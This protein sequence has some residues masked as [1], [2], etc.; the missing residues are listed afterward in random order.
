M[1]E[2]FLEGMRSILVGAVA[3]G[4][5]R[6]L[7]LVLEEGQIIDTIIH[8]VVEPLQGLPETVTAVLMMFVQS[9]LNFLMPSS[10]GQAAATLPLFL[11]IGD[12]VGLGRR[13]TIL[14]FQFGDS[15]TNLIYPTYGGL[16]AF[17]MFAK[18]PYNKW[19]RFMLPFV[20]VITIVAAV[21]VAIA[22]MIGF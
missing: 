14:A 5:S 7:P 18:I 12:L 22:D 1:I 13:V 4:M 17:L 19:V 21:L 9:L 8:A 11:P 16:I 2:T 10:A 15:L 3:V 20:V 6:A